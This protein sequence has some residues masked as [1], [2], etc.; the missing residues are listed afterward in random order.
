MLEEHSFFPTRSFHWLENRFPVGTL[1]HS[2]FKIAFVAASPR[3]VLWFSQAAKTDKCTVGKPTTE[4]CSILT[5]PW[6]TRNLL[7]MF[8]FILM[9]ICWP[10]VP[11][12]LSIKWTYSNILSTTPTSKQNHFKRRRRAEQDPYPSHHRQHRWRPRIRD[13]DRTRWLAIVT[14]LVHDTPMPQEQ[15]EVSTRAEL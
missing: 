4:I 1:A 3:A 12:V 15:N 5:K 2:I 13:S 7:L 10:C 9:T 6:I 8:N 11:S 14:T